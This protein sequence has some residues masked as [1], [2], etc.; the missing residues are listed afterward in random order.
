MVE[1]DIEAYAE[2]GHEHKT[3]HFAPFNFAFQRDGSEAMGGKFKKCKKQECFQ[4][5]RA[6]GTGILRANSIKTILSSKWRRCIVLTN[7]KRNEI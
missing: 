3:Q 1:S 5:M 7:F 4:I 2:K 6:R